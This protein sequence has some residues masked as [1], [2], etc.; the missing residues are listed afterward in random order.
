[1]KKK[2]LII[3]SGF[4]ALATAFFLTK[5]K[6]D[7]SVFY[8]KNLKGVLG[9]VNIEDENFDLGYQF[10]DG[11]D[12]Q[13]EEFINE[14]FGEDTLHNFKYGAS[15]FSNNFFYKD[16]A[17]P[18][19]PAYG[20]LFIINAFIFYLYK[21]IKSKFFPKVKKYNNLSEL[22]NEL[23]P[24]IKKII[25]GGCKKNYQISPEK[26]D[27][28]A[29]KMS[30]FT[31][32]RQTLFNDKISNFLKEKFKYFDNNL[33]SRRVSNS[34]L[35]NISLYPVKKN[36]EFL[37]D[38]IINKLNTKGVIFRN[39]DFENLKINNFKNKLKVNEEIFDDIIIT[40]GLNN[41]QRIFNFNK[42]QNYEHFISQVFLYFTVKTLNFDYQYTQM[43]DINLKCS[44]I[45]N[46]SL[47]SKLT[48]KGH[49]VL[50]AEIPLTNT[51]KLWHDDSKLK[52]IAWNEI[53]KCGIVKKD[54]KFETVKVIKVNK[55]FPVPKVDFF[56]FLDKFKSKIQENYNNKI[57]FVGQGIFTRHYFVRELMNKLAKYE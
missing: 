46:C 24:N 21:L 8:E 30:T 50:I 13:T 33:A 56:N 35:E 14:M 20:N 25:I 22:Y 38:K 17:I 39:L 47:Y 52:D 54:T 16:H 41:S 55:T 29:Y 51:N 28:E 23:P 27:I 40:T 12:K 36:M 57:K 32:I 19:W 3:G 31:Q 10:F 42:E 37:A 6:I 44:R 11:L 43:N 53:I 45:S 49:H 2:V 9:S 15:T 7:V 1:M 18:Y 26:L 5:K 34:K 4:N 48:K